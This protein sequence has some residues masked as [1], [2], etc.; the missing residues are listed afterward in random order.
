[1]NPVKFC[2]ECNN[3]LYPFEYRELRTF[4]FF[5]PTCYHQETIHLSMYEQPQVLQDAYANRT[6]PRAWGVECPVCH[7]PEVV[8][9][10]TKTREAMA[11]TFACCRQSCGRNFKE[12]ARITI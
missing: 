8:F 3:L 9:F 7:Y 10:L 6:L 11:L 4:C 2:P 1:M 5:C 12:R